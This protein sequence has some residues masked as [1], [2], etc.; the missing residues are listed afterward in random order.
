MGFTSNPADFG[1]SEAEQGVT[2]SLVGRQGER[3]S[4]IVLTQ[5]TNNCFCFRSVWT[6][7]LEQKIVSYTPAS[8]AA[9]AELL[10]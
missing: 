1:W 7:H 10:V 5:Q 2:Q 8:K 3:P 4:S 6:Q 9:T